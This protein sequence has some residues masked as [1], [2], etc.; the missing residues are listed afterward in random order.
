MNWVTA[1]LILTFYLCL[2]SCRIYFS[3]SFRKIIAKNSFLDLSNMCATA[4]HS[5]SQPRTNNN[6]I[7]EFKSIRFGKAQLHGLITI[8]KRVF[9]FYKYMLCSAMLSS[10]RTKYTIR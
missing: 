1:I 2:S 6:F 7:T 10:I 4:S 8:N 9:C 5:H 3:I